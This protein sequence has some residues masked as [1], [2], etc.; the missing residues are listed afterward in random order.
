MRF[1][2]IAPGPIKTEV[3]IIGIVSQLLIVEQLYKPG[4]SKFFSLRTTLAMRP[5]AGGRV[6]LQNP[7]MV[8]TRSWNSGRIR[9]FYFQSRKIRRK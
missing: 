7:N 2:A 6:H 3:L 9:E 1:N 8:T 4:V 5:Q